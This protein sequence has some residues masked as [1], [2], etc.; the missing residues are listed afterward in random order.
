MYNLYIDFDGVVWDTWPGFYEHVKNVNEVLY[1][2]WINNNLDDN[3]SQELV[4][5]LRSIDWASFLEKT[6]PLNNSLY[7]I[8]QLYNTGLFNI[9]ILTHCN[10]ENESLNKIKLVA[11]VLPL[12]KIITVSKDVSKTDVVDP[13]GAILVDDYGKNI[14]VW[15]VNGGIGIKYVPSIKPN[16]PYH[17][18]ESLDQ[19]MNIV[20]IENEINR[21]VKINI[22]R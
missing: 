11:N 19:V 6:K 14:E 16:Y 22:R 3:D 4:T 17:Q 8:M 13:V 20:N 2:K 18:I 9:T 7:H 15:E 10:S 21:L 5:I 12:I 1:D